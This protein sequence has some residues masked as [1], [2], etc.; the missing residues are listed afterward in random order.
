MKS[1]SY[2]LKQASRHS[3][4][5][6]RKWMYRASKARVEIVSYNPRPGSHLNNVTKKA[7]AIAKKKACVVEFIFN[8]HI[9]RVDRR[10]DVSLVSR[11]YK[12]PQPWD[13]NEETVI[14]PEYKQNLSKKE[15]SQDELIS[16]IN[17]I[18]YEKLDA[19]RNRKQDEQLQNLKELLSKSEP[20]DVIDQDA[21]DDWESKN[22]DAYGGRIFSYAKDWGRLMQ[23]K[24]SQG[25]SLEQCADEMS[26]TADHDGITGYM[27]AAA[28]SVLAKCWKH[29][30]QLN[31]LRSAG[32]I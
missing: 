19:E 12:R 27:F 16:I 30:E 25:E 26:K 7:I 15:A 28:C 4:S 23:A 32:K 6:Q 29:G 9:V 24:M 5:Q 11:D 1:S 17:D 18:H 8:N 2:Y 13:H 10:S 21:W 20:L 31:E 14:G 22:T 3:K